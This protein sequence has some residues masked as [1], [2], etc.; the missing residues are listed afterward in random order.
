MCAVAV[1][2]IF[3]DFQ[4]KNLI[5]AHNADGGCYGALVSI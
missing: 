4:G 1:A 5:P 3:G 2:G